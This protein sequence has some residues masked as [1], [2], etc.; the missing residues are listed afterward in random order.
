MPSGAAAPATG[1]SAERIQNGREQL[2]KRAEK[3][4]EL[5]NERPE[6]GLGAAFVGGL[7]LA[8]ILKRLAR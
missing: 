5:V 7:I 6:V 4:L 1:S 8:S 3:F 2:E